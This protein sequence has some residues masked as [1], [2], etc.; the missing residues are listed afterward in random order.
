MPEVKTIE[1]LQLDGGIPC[2]D[3]VNAAVDTEVD[4]LVERLHTYSDLLVLAERSGLLDRLVIRSLSAHAKS[5]PA[6]ANAVMLKMREV[7]EDMYTVFLDLATHKLKQVDKGALD[8]LN[9]AIAWA[10]SARKLEVVKNKIV[11]V[12]DMDAAGL[13]LPLRAFVMSAQDL[14]LNHRQELVKKCVSCAWLFLDTS[15]SHRRK[16]C[17]MQS[18]G[19]AAKSKRY[20]RRKTKS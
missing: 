13:S 3:L 16:W 10:A 5:R 1:E 14:L 19:S 7:R 18:C 17:D 15:K 8:R 12:W 2:L 6:E 9:V 20:Y 4:V 11:P